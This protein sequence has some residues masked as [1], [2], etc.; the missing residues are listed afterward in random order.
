MHLKNNK[1]LY[2]QA[3]AE[4]ICDY[5]GVAYIPE[6]SDQPVNQPAPVTPTKPSAPAPAPK[7][8]S[9]PNNTRVV[10][11]ILYVRD[12]NGNRIPGRY[13]ANGDNITVLDVSYSKQLA[14]V[15]YPTTSGVESGYVKNVPSLIQYYNQGQ[16]HNGSTPETVCGED[17][18][19]IGRL[20]PREAASPLYRK[21]GRLHVV[22]NT[23]SKGAN[24]KSGNV[25]YNGGFNKF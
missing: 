20:D 25:A 11:D 5:F 8:F 24:T 19:A 9:Y 1:D 2:A 23:I 14:L 10:D 17:G 16:W 7:G 15:G 6:G 22:Y 13:V 3:T 18:T 21:N 12:A 4:G